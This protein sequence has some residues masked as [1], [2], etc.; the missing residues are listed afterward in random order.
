MNPFHQKTLSLRTWILLYTLIIMS[1][2][3]LSATYVS[4]ALNETSKFSI[5]LNRQ[6]LRQTKLIRMVLQRTAD[7]ERKARLYMV[8]SDA[9]TGGTYELE[10]YEITRAALKQ[11][12][13]DLLETP[14]D[15]KLTLLINELSEKEAIINKQIL[16]PERQS[17]ERLLDNAFSGL[18]EASNVLA[19]EFENYVDQQ[20]QLV[21]KQSNHIDGLFLA[22][23][24]AL[25]IIA[26]FS[27][28]ALVSVIGR[29]IH[30][31]DIATQRMLAGNFDHP[32]GIFGLKELARLA[33][34]LELLRI[35][36]KSASE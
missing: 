9:S 6:V 26:L 32:V 18:R 23:G 19:R 15:N 30:H 27:A 3:F 10:S 28:G 33:Q 31:L 34:H 21:M 11:E 12:L 20:S 24:I 36:S 14:L 17:S 35:H 4:H 16:S 7:V 22:V 5:E 1:P 29:P 2:L 13:N 25:I 8:L